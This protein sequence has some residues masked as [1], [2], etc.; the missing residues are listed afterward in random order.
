[1]LLP[2]RKFIAGSVLAS[3]ILGTPMDESG[4]TT[5]AGQRSQDWVSPEDFGAVGD[6]VADDT[7]AVQRALDTLKT[8]RG[9]PGAQ[10]L[11]RRASRQL[12]A[13]QL[14]SGMRWEGNGS[15]IK[16]ADAQQPCALI[17]TEYTSTPGDVVSTGISLHGRFDGN[18]ANQGAIAPSGNYF[19]PTVYCDRVA[20]SDFDVEIVN[21]YIAGFYS[22]GAYET[23]RDNR[24]RALVRGGVGAGVNI[25]GT[26]WTV[27]LSDVSDMVHDSRYAIGNSSVFDVRDSRIGDV[28]TRNCGWG[29]KFQE[30]MARTAIGNVVNIA[31]PLTLSDFAVKFQGNGITAWNEDVTVESVLCEGHPA[32]GLYLYANRG[33]TI[34]TYTGR[35]NGTDSR[36]NVNNRADCQIIDTEV[37]IGTLRSEHAAGVPVITLGETRSVRVGLLDVVAPRLAHM[38]VYARGNPA[39]G[40]STVRISTLSVSDTPAGWNAPLVAVENKSE[41]YVGEVST[42]AL[43]SDYA[44]VEDVV[45]SYAPAS[46]WVRIGQ[47]TW[48][49]PWRRRAAHHSPTG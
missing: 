30:T 23:N 45:I 37:S 31:G 2:R 48:V 28:L 38:L 11:C 49:S 4:S 9:T 36:L 13:L 7:A 29:V 35:R 6:G 17:K 42:D 14:R 24:L 32:T 12:Y 1:M 39:V 20:E 40:R 25:I 34:G 19:Q 27:P 21:A 8:A 3:T 33:L 26:R 47:I 5:R 46:S 10:Y 22:S 43:L 41:V 15:T 16:L 44:K 18:S